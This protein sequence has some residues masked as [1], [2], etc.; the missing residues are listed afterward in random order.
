MKNKIKI[1][2]L[3]IFCVLLL[4]GCGGRAVNNSPENVAREMANR[5]SSGNYKNIA[6]L[7]G[8]DFLSISE[9]RFANFVNANNL[10]IRGNRTLKLIKDNNLD[11]RIVRFEIDNNRILEI[12]TREVNGKWFVDLSNFVHSNLTINVPT[13]STVKVDGIDIS[14]MRTET[15]RTENRRERA[16]NNFDFTF[17]IGIDVYTIP[18]LFPGEYSLEVTHDKAV[19]FNGT[20]DSR[21]S[22]NSSELGLSADRSSNAYTV[23]LST[24][25]QEREA[26]IAFYRQYYEELLETFN[27]RG[28]FSALSSHLDTNNTTFTAIFSATMGRL[29]RG[30]PSNWSYVYSDMRLTNIE[31]DD[32][33]GGVIYLGGNRYALF[34]TTNFTFV[35]SSLNSR[36]PHMNRAETRTASPRVFVE[37]SKENGSYRIIGGNPIFQIN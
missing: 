17:D 22:R 35:Y 30:G 8:E 23:S 15:N 3:G 11:E 12:T 5:L 16:S 36:F 1:L 26:I 20:I 18:T 4:T 10:N 34:T 6:D 21:I 24:S 13:G 28:E 19:T 7:L 25:P 37:I 29:N 2:L 14:D 32:S 33:L 9:E 27:A 31:V